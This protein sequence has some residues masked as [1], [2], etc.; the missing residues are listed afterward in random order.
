MQ[1]RLFKKIKFIGWILF[2]IIGWFIIAS[3][4]NFI[5]RDYQKKFWIDTSKD[6]YWEEIENTY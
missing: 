6:Y 1:G 5:F 2:L 4:V 3:I